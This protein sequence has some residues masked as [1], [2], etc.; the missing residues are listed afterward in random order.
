M[1]QK[2][3]GR[4]YQEEGVMQ[5]IERLGYYAEA[6]VTSSQYYTLADYSCNRQ[7]YSGEAFPFLGFDGNTACLRIGPTYMKVP[8]ADVEVVRLSEHRELARI[9]SDLLGRYQKEMR[10]HYGRQ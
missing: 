4:A 3:R 2:A 6:K 10:D 8:A 9:Y 5:K 1:D 7:L